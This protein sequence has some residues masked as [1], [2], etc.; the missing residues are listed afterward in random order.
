VA[1][2]ILYH[3]SIHKIQT[4]DVTRG[5]PYKDFGRGFYTTRT[6]SHAV[7]LARRNQKLKNDALII[8]EKKPDAKAWLYTYE[9]DDEQVQSLNV[10]NFSDADNEWARFV[11]ANR[12]N[13]TPQ[14]E[15]DMVIGPTADDDTGF[16]VE[17]LMS[18]FYGDPE[19][20]EAIE[21]FLRLILANK[22]PFQTYFGTQKAADLLSLIDRRAI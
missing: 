6:E 20:D 14:H 13:K 5:R 7:K 8:D 1:R 3:G 22:L 9:F 4:I 16:T 19:S 17:A 10:M 15:Y 11:V 2:V 18:Y 21:I 12:S